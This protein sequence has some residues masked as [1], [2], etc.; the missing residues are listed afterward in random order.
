M[1]F[2]YSSRNFSSDYFEHISEIL[3]EIPQEIRLELPLGFIPTIP[4]SIPL[5]EI[6]PSGI[7]AKNYPG[8]SRGILP[9]IPPN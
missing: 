8:V 6:P 2:G 1:I 4:S 5:S 3:P 7:F 9:E